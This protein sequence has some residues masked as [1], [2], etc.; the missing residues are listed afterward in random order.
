M[1]H[2]P[3][4]PT[5]LIADDDADIRE[6]LSIVLQIH[7]LV[8]VEAGDGKEALDIALRTP[9][10]ALVLLDL[11]MPGM[12]GADFLEAA[13]R[14]PDLARIPVLVL[15]GDRRALETASALGA[16][17]CLIKPVELDDLMREIARFVPVNADP[18]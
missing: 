7:H 12:S 2:S 3:H 1:T 11:M 9:G 5:V 8:T 10:L 18:R 14:E 17:G 13:R 4:E 6:M 16:A 15:S